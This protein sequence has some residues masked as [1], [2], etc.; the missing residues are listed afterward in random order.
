MW[1][2]SQILNLFLALLLNAFDSDPEEDD[3]SENASNECEI[4]SSDSMSYKL[5]SFFKQL[6]TT[7]STPMKLYRKE[8]VPWTEMSAINNIEPFSELLHNMDADAIDVDKPL[9][10]VRRKLQLQLKLSKEG[11]SCYC[12]AISCHDFRLR[13]K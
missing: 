5:K 9:T 7:Y 6:A 10:E 3:E 13:L 12:W 11:K 8:N 4:P 2:S 1:F